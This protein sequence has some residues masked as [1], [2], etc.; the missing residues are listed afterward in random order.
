MG[1]ADP[2]NARRALDEGEAFRYE[3][4]GKTRK[5]KSLNAWRRRS[6]EW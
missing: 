2:R 3:A 6:N 1:S 4:F 5:R